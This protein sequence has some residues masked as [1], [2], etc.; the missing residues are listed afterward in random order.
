MPLY[1][2]D[3]MPVLTA[4]NTEYADC[5]NEFLHFV[6]NYSMTNDIYAAL[7]AADWYGEE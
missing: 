7:S 6:E 2:R 1:G 5:R 4:E 3:I